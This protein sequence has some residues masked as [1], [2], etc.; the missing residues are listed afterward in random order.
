MIKNKGLT[1]FNTPLISPLLRLLA[2]AGLKLSG[3]KT[4]GEAPKLNKY[5]LIAAP[6]TSNWDFFPMVSVVLKY[7]LEVHWIGKHTL[8]PFPIR[9]FVRWMGGIPIDRRAARNTVEQVAQAYNRSD[10]LALV[11]APEGTRGKVDN[12]KAGFYHIATSVN[13]PIQATFVDSRT[14]TTGFGPLFHPTGDYEKDLSEIRAFY[15]D[16]VGIRPELT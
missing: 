8:F 15:A 10:K 9:W 2:T 6:H 5:V 4:V 7:K 3:W 11:I 16:K 12:W 13:V 14:K 1:I